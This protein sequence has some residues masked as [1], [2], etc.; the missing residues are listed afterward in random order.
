MLHTDSDNNSIDETISKAG[1]VRR[2]GTPSISILN[3][4]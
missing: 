3:E 2:G 4:N 1:A